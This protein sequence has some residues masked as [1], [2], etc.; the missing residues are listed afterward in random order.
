MKKHHDHEEPYKGKHL[1]GVQY[2]I[3]MAGQGGVQADKVME[4]RVL[5]RDLQAIESELNHWTWLEHV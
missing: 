4:L 3:L 1:I 2:I 5:H